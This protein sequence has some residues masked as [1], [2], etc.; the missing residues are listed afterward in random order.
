MLK[1]DWWILVYVL[2]WK[3]CRPFV[4]IYEEISIFKSVRKTVV[5]NFNKDLHYSVL[6][7]I[8]ILNFLKNYTEVR[9]IENETNIFADI[10]QQKIGL[11]RHK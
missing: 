5:C 2:K 3:W 4:K 7:V 10:I 6:Y 9:V 11:R 1:L 8:N